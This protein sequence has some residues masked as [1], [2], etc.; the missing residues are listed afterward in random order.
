[1]VFLHATLVGL[2]ILISFA[3]F[4]ISLRRKNKIQPSDVS[5]WSLIYELMIY[6]LIY[7]AGIKGAFLIILYLVKCH[8][9]RG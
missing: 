2:L 4:L 9:L 5:A 1:M 7:Q 8:F 3:V 6:E